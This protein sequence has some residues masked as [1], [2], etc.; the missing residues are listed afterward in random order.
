M[1]MLE[2]VIIDD[3]KDNSFFFSESLKNAG[4]MN[5]VHIFDDPNDFLESGIIPDVIFTD[6]NMPIMN[7]VEFIQKVK[8]NPKYDNCILSVV[9]GVKNDI[10][11]E[12]ELAELGV[13]YFFVKPIPIRALNEVLHEIQDFWMAWIRKQNVI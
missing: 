1:K 12:K 13:S 3:C 7:G 8:E 9:S 2:F 6:I 10:T 5:E 11:M 4:Y